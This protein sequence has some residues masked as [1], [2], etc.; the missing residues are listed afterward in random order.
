LEPVEK[1]GQWGLYRISGFEVEKVMILE[2]VFRMPE[3]FK[4]LMDGDT[5]MGPLTVPY[6][7]GRARI[8]KKSQ[9]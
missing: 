6:A 1:A 5:S 2:D 7:A 4:S 9:D 3:V 8:E